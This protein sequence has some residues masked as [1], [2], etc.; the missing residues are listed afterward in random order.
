MSQGANVFSSS[1]GVSGNNLTS[2][3][4]SDAVAFAKAFDLLQ[5]SITKGQ[6][7]GKLGS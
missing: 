2:S 6:W 3:D 1:F 7:V 4:N 5:N